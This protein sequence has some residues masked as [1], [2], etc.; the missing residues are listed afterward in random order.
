[1]RPEDNCGQIAL[2]DEEKE[3]SEISKEN[4]AIYREVR[5][6]KTCKEIPLGPPRNNETQRKSNMEAWLDSSLPATL[7]VLL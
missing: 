3:G 7:I 4:Q 6:R 5:K 2:K 1:M